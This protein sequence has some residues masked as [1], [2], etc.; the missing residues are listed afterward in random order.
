MLKAAREEKKSPLEI[1]AFYTEKFFKDFERLNIDKPEIICKATDHIKEMEEFAQKLMEN[2]YAYETSTAI[3]FDVS[4]LDRYGLL[5]GIDVRKQMAGARIEVDEE[6]KNPYDFALWIKAPENHIMKWESKWGLC[7]PGW[8]IECSTMSNKYLGEV[9]DIHTGGIDLIPTHHENEIAQSK[10]CTGKI[11]A[12]FWMHCEYL[13]INGGK[14]SKSLGNAYLVQDIIDKGYDPLAFKMMCFTSHYR[15][16][17]NFTWEALE[18]SQN[19]L[20]KLR[21]GFKKHLEG[22]SKAQ[23]SVIEEYKNKFL[24]AINDDLNMPVAMSVI[25]DVIKNPNK[26]KSLADLLLEFDK[27]LGVDINKEKE[28]N[29]IELPEEISK[30][31]EDRR[32]AREEKNWDL[33]DKIRDELKE[34]GYIVKDTKEGMQVEKI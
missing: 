14:M 7:Y 26:S 34:K 19:S 32:K 10:G 22:N 1:A 24:E 20:T 12:R 11:P 31:L 33:S 21:D 6:K 16:K 25:W 13:L 15:N 29:N 3:Y 8:H 23:A 28:E 17:L 9:F 27:V 18:S 2:G 4:K 30:M 5:S